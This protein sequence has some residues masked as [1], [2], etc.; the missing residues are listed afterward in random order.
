M[1]K[2]NETNSKNQS[3]ENRFEKE[4]PLR[5]PLADVAQDGKSIKIDHQLYT[6]VVNERDALDL[7]M[8]RKKY[9][10]YLDQY[11][12]LVG[13]VSSDHLRLKGFY[14]DVVRTSIDK[15]E[16]AIV[17][18]LTEYCNPGGP[19][20][21][22]ELTDPV[23]HYQHQMPKRKREYSREHNRNERFHQRRRYNK[24]HKNDNNPFKKRRVHQ[25]KFKKKQSVAVKKKLGRHHS[26]V[27]KKR[28]GK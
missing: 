20:F 2:K 27:I 23:H 11:D 28:K 18:Y 4:Q 15:K 14:K 21:I 3:S 9:D 7:K 13:D 22:L 24:R 6:I 8:L 5:H 19:Y 10:P 12:Y 1:T 25:T 16:L 17:D 26:F